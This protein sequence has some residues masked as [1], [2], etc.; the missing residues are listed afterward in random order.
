MSAS[1]S[2]RMPPHRH[3]GKVFVVLDGRHRS[4]GRVFLPASRSLPAQC[5]ARPG[6]SRVHALDISRSHSR[7]LRSPSCCH[8]T[9]A[10]AQLSQRRASPLSWMFPALAALRV[11]IRA[12]DSG[13]VWMMRRCRRECSARVMAEGEL[14]RRRDVSGEHHPLPRLNELQEQRTLLDVQ[15]VR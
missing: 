15:I 6:S 9:G 11:P 12:A 2:C 5:S 3:A 7:W 13:V 8:G 4:V 14:F 1:F 10:V